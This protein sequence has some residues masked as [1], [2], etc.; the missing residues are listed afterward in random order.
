[1]NMA[2]IAEELINAPIAPASVIL[3]AAAELHHRL[4]QAVHDPGI[5][6]ALADDKDRGDQN[7]DRIAETGERFMRSEHAGKDQRQHDQDS[8]DI[9]AWTSPGKQH[10][11]AGQDAKN[12]QHRA[13]HGRV[14][15][16]DAACSLACIG[17]QRLRVCALCTTPSSR[18]LAAC[19]GTVATVKIGRPHIV[20]LR[21]AKI[22][23]T[24]EILLQRR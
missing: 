16:A 11:G 23:L 15:V 24:Q 10:Y 2:T 17:A 8:N 9:D 7:H 21:F 5:H 13:G 22:D 3:I 6:Q 1:M 14:P 19:A 20:D 18:T 4:A 12:H